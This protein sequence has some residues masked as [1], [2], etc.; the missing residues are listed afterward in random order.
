M[1]RA[2]LSQPGSNRTINR[3]H[4]IRFAEVQKEKTSFIEYYS[5]APLDIDLHVSQYGLPLQTRQISNFDDFSAKIPLTEDASQLLE[6]NGFVVI[7]NPFNPQ[8]EDITMPY[9]TMKEREIPIFITSDSLLHLYHVQ[10]GETLRQIEEREF[11]DAI[12]EISTE[13]LNDSVEDYNLASGDLKEASKRNVAYF[14]VGLCL[15]QPKS[16]QVCQS[17]HDWECTDAYFKRE[18]IERYS[19]ELPAF[20][21]SDV[22]KELEFRC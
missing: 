20:V 8:E 22:E 15:L 3:H 19:F 5:L 7:R 6:K 18:E 9:S 2:R 10:F 16:E 4:H 1:H 13:L 21:K 12:W 11:Y 17:Q 14:A